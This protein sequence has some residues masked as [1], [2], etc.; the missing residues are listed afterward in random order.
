MHMIARSLLASLKN[1][2][3]TC[4]IGRRENLTYVKTMIPDIENVLRG[5]AGKISVR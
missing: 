3:A 2:G 4:V 5:P 1:H